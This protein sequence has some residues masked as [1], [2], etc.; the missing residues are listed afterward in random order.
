MSADG[1]TSLSAVASLEPYFAEVGE[2]VLKSHS[3]V[4]SNR[5]KVSRCDISPHWSLVKALL[6]CYCCGSDG[7][8]RHSNADFS[9]KEAVQLYRQVL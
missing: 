6:P 5:K 9:L 4:L 3:L 7:R 8:S 1:E 2:N